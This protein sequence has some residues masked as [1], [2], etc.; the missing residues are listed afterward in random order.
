V[1]SQNNTPALNK[2]INKLSE[3]QLTP[4]TQ[5]QYA[6]LD[7]AFMQEAVW[8]PYGN[9]TLSTFVSSDINLDKIIWNPTFEDDFTS[10]QFK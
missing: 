5:K 1:F 3:Q 10:I 2:Q 4:Q 9:R 6:A 7:K 8:A